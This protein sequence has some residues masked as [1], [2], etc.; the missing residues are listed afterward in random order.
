MKSFTLIASV[1]GDGFAPSGSKA[2]MTEA[3]L[4]KIETSLSAKDSEISTLKADAQAKQSKIDELEATVADLKK[5]PAADTS[6]V[7]E[8]SA[9]QDTDG[10]GDDIDAVVAELSKAFMA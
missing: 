7:K 9:K 5:A 10:P 8:T 6:D 4:D 3:Q 1:V 2:E